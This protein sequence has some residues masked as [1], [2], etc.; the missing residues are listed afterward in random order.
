MSVYYRTFSLCHHLLDH[1]SLDVPVSC[2]LQIKHCLEPCQIAKLSVIRFYIELEGITK[3][4]L[5]VQGATFYF[6]LELLILLFRGAC[7]R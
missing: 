2:V 3:E 6:N 1:F 4:L 5:G 7:L